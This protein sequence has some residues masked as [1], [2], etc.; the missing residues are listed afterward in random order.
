MKSTDPTTI[1]RALCATT[2]WFLEVQLLPCPGGWAAFI[3]LDPNMA[4]ARAEQQGLADKSLSAAANDPRVRLLW[5]G[6]VAAVND[7]LSAD[8]RIVSHTPLL[9][10]RLP[11]ADVT[12]RGLDQ[13][14]P[15]G[16]AVIGD[17]W[18]S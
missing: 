11:A 3:H 12:L 4:K 14:R 13:R 16:R 8:V 15:A 7:A 1:A 10:T 6:Y 2:A 9:D 5:A 18:I 17:R